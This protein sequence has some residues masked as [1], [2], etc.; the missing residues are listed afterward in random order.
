MVLFNSP[1]PYDKEKMAGMRTRPP[2]EA[3]DYF[4][5]QGT[6][7]DALAAE[8]ATPE[9]RR[10]YIATFYTSRFW[11]H[12]GAFSPEAVDFMTEPFA[13]AASLRASF[14]GYESAFNERARSEPPMVATMKTN[15]TWT[16]ILFGPSDHVLYP[17]FDLMAAAVFPDHVGPYLLRDCGHFVQWEAASIL[18]NSIASFCSDLLAGVEWPDQESP[19]VEPAALDEDTAGRVFTDELVHS[20]RRLAREFGYH[21]T[22]FM[23]VV[24]DVGAVNAARRFA[25]DETVHEGLW[26][27]KELGAAHESVEHMVL[28]PRFRAL[29]SVEVRRVAY[30]KLQSLGVTPRWPVE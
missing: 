16:M 20:V 24:G 7:A 6:D 13:N 12:P 9:M 27:L 4:V 30:A 2:R 1:L 25:A 5:R 8:L 14:G 10:R 3:S 26:R 23:Q 29:F 28:D 19:A 21:P 22:R 15:P 17:D 18:N 11:A